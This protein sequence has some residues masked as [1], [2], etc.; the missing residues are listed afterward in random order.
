MSHDLLN[1][2]FSNL[3]EH[4]DLV[5]RGIP[6]GQAAG[7]VFK[8]D[9]SSEILKSSP[10]QQIRDV[11]KQQAVRV[12]ILAQNYFKGATE[13]QLSEA[14]EQHKHI[15]FT[16]PYHYI[17]RAGITLNRI[18]YSQQKTAWCL[19]FNNLV[20]P[21]VDLDIQEV[22]ALLQTLENVLFSS[23]VENKERS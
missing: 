10:V 3:K 11:L 6:S 2:H 19:H 16:N 15:K 17:N 8:E 9:L 13:A 23:V 22:L 20:I 7:I 18:K 5:N 4:A 1:Q 14:V 12:N 21:V